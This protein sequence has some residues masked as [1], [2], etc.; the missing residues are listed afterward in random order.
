M[1]QQ[2]SFSTGQ[3]GIAGNNHLRNPIP[4]PMS[5]LTS[6]LKQIGDIRVNDWDFTALMHKDIRELEFT[7][8]LR[9]LGKLK[10]M[11]LD[12]KTPMPVVNRLANQEVD[13]IDLFKRTARYK[14][15]NWDF[16]APLPT[17]SEATAPKPDEPSRPG[18][19]EMPAI[20]TGLKDFLQYVVVNLIDEPEHAQMRVMEIDPGVLRFNLVLVKRDV[21]MLIGREGH[22][23]AAIRS[24]LKAAAGMHGVHALLEIISLE[25]NIIKQQPPEKP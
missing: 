16:N 9:L 20:T 1:M 6:S 2:W 4:K 25:E 15:M 23:A 24:L 14:V 8:S 12:I 11:E 22:T 17:K 3:P 21:A 5:K 18:P 7:R 10:V 19:E 13:L